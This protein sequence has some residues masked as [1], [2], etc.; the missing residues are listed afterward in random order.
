MIPFTNDFVFVRPIADAGTE[1]EEGTEL[2]YSVYRATFDSPQ[3][4]LIGEITATARP[5]RH[6]NYSPV[7]WMVVGESPSGF[8]LRGEGVYTFSL[9]PP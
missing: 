8:V 5:D 2:H 9:S 3:A 1:M 4:V 7:R 6:A